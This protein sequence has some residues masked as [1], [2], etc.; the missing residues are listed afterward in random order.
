MNA[1][2]VNL[3][4]AEKGMRGTGKRGRI[5]E[6]ESIPGPRGN[7]DQ[8]TPTHKGH[9]LLPLKGGTINTANAQFRS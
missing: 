7:E 4:R 8:F 6:E 5:E 2:I 3:F 9:E 1:S